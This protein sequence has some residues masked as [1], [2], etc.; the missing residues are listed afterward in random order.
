MRLLCA[1]LAIFAASV[2]CAQI[3]GDVNRDGK[4]DTSDAFLALEAHVVLKP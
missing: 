1:L 3:P 2:A 4:L